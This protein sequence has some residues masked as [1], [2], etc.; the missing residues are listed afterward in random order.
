MKLT[1][2]LTVTVAAIA[3]AIAGPISAGPA[4]LSATC[5]AA[6]K[7]TRT[8]AVKAF[9][10]GQVARRRAYFRAHTKPAARKAF[11]QRERARLRELGLAAS[12]TVL[13]PPPAAHILATIPVASAGRMA[14]AA[15]G[16]LWVNR[17]YPDGST[18]SR[19][20]PATNQVTDTVAVSAGGIDIAYGFGSIWEVD[21]G[22]GNAAGTVSRIDPQTKA[23]IATIPT[24]GTAPGGIVIT[25]QAVWVANH[26]EPPIPNGASI[27]KI[28]PATNRVVDTILV[29]AADGGGPV[30]L[31]TA[32]GSIW[33][34]DFLHRAI[35]R[36]DPVSDKVLATLFSPLSINGVAWMV[37][38]GSQVWFATNHALGV[39]RVDP[40][41]N[42]ITVTVPGSAIARYG[43][44]A[45]WGIVLGAGS[46]WLSGPC[47]RS[48]CVLRVDPA[49]NT[50]VSAWSV[51]VSGNA[52]D[53]GG[54]AY[55]AGS[56]WLELGNTVVRIDPGTP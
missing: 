11:L 34:E 22:S 15:D 27:V 47:G 13:L 50:I 5:T 10:L 8:Q 35:V 21:Y 12:C 37:T 14:F 17:D 1:M 39:Q 23:V 9:E 41:S 16:S 3:A 54:L 53:V 26:D 32:G 4:R 7:A 18:I 29:G 25:P 19:I 30:S 45:N 24:Q 42:T 51:P 31:A 36:I 28:D 40:A 6:E 20:D 44:Q 2:A 55:G 56:L 46:L 52:E 49:T 43:L 33:A 38:D 48:A